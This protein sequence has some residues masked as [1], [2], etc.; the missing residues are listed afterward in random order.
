MGAWDS[1]RIR[2]WAVVALLMAFS[3]AWATPTFQTYIKGGTAGDVGAIEDT[4]ITHSGTFDLVV[5]GAYAGNTAAL[6][7]GTLVVSVPQGETGTL[8]IGGAPLL[9]ATRTTGVG[10][11]PNGPATLDLLSNVGGMDGYDNK[12][13]VLDLNNHFPYQNGV[14][15]FLY[16]AVGN[17]ADSGP[18]HNRDAQ[19]DSITLEGTGEEKTFAVSVTG[20]SWVHFDLGGYVDKEP[21]RDAW[22]INPGGHDATYISGA[23]IPAPSSLLLAILGAGLVSRY[24]RRKAL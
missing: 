7:W 11:I 13:P 10:D 9:T 21:G 12:S 15:N 17:F 23:V 24:R 3:S 16:Y 2:F 14:A 1:G 18:I 20:F 6:T 4:W 5:V 8:T 19:T 22:E